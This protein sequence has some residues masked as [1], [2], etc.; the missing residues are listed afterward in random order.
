MKIVIDVSGQESAAVMRSLDTLD[1][2][3][4]NECEVLFGLVDLAIREHDDGSPTEGFM[5]RP[6]LE[7]TGNKEWWA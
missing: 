6:C 2:C 1:I 4:C 5:C 3:S 7:A